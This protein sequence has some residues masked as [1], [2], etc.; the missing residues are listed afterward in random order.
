VAGGDDP[1]PRQG[2]AHL[3]IALLLAAAFLVPLS[4]YGRQPRVAETQA[5]AS[6]RALWDPPRALP[7]PENRR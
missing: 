4:A 6:V 3:A 5:L 1:S 2:A 7:L